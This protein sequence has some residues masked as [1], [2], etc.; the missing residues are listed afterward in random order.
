MINEDYLIRVNKSLEDAPDLSKWGRGVLSF[1]EDIRGA[2]D[3]LDQSIRETREALEFLGASVSEPVYKTERSK[4][5]DGFFW[6]HSYE[7]EVR[8]GR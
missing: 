5:T 2:K 8:K 4:Y 1:S 3:L 6:L 7:L